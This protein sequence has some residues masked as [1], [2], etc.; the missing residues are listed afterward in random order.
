M[1]IRPNYFGAE[2]AIKIVIIYKIFSSSLVSSFHIE[3]IVRIEIYLHLKATMKH[4]Q[5]VA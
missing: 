1:E 2:N 3:S 5:T 4:T